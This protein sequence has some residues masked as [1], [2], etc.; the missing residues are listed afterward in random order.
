MIG[1]GCPLPLNC[2]SSIPAR[3]CNYFFQHFGISYTD[4][5]S[6]PLLLDLNALGGTYEQE[7]TPNLFPHSLLTV[8][9]HWENAS[10]QR[11]QL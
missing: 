4:T 9:I 10:T 11:T 8:E 6:S 5:V 3:S 2:N 7:A 1:S